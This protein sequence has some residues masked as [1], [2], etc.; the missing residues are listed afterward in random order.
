MTFVSDA[1]QQLLS[2][3]DTALQEG[4]NPPPDDNICLRVGQ[5]PFDVGLSQDLCCEGFAWVRVLRIFPSV[6]FPNPDSIPNDCQNSSYAVEFELGAIRCL[7]FGS[8]HAGPTCDEWTSV[9]TQVDEDAASMR[10]AICC[11]RDL[12]D[13][14]MTFIDQIIVGEWIPIDGQG[15]CI[16]G[17]MNVTVHISCNECE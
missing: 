4:P 7:P 17:Q 14:N 11:I 8:E 13:A 1:A 15:G 2:C 3:Y 9:F 6:N 5:V 10:R 12:Q 16:G